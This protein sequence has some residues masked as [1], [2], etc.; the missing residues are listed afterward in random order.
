MG[1]EKVLAPTGV[2]IAG[3]H[4]SAPGPAKTAEMTLADAAAANDENGVFSLLHLC[5]H[6]YI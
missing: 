1:L 3:G 5:I 4:F 2:G 6:A